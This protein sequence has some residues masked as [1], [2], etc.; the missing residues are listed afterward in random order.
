[1]PEA[2]QRLF[3]FPVRVAVG[4]AG[5]ACAVWLTNEVKGVKEEKVLVE[6]TH[7]FQKLVENKSRVTS[8]YDN[9]ST[10]SILTHLLLK[11][12]NQNMCKT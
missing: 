1:M 3:L 6:N 8:L 5:C 4:V 10:Q 9:Q 12:N 7:L 2:T 11:I